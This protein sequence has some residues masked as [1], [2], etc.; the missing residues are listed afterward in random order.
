MHRL[1]F[2]ASMTLVAFVD[3]KMAGDVFFPSGIYPV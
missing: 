1:S 2:H 3:Y